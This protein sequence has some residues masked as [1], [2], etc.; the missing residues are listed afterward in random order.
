VRSVSADA[1]PIP[2]GDPVDEEVL[3][4]SVMSMGSRARGSR[5]RWLW[6]SLLPFGLGSWVPIVAGARCEVRRWTML[7]VLWSILAAVGWIAGLGE[8]TEGAYEP[9]SLLL[10]IV[11]WVGGFGTT[12]T[13][14]SSYTRQMA[15]RS[16]EAPARSDGSRAR[17]PWLSLLPLGVGV[18]APAVAGVRCGVR[19]WT[20]LGVVWS[21][22]ALVGWVIAGGS[23]PG[24][25]TEGLGVGLI[26][27][28]WIAGIV[29]S[30]VIRPRYERRAERYAPVRA[31]CPQ[32]TARSRQWTLRYALIAYVVT[33][34]VVVTSAAVLYYGAS[35]QLHVGVGVLIVDAILLG[36]LVPLR[37]RRGLTRQDLGLRATPAAR[38]I[39]L[40]ILAFV[41]YA[42]VAGVWV[43]VVHPRGGANTLAD[44]R[45][46]STINV[47]LAVF[48]VAVS[49]P[50]VEEIF[51]RG[52]L[53]RS[54]RNRLALLPAAL[55]A[56]TMFGLVHIT[57]YPLDTLPVKA[58]FGVIT[59]LLYERTGSLLP[60]I[61]LHSF[62]DATSIDVSLT[63]NDLIVLASFLSLAVVLLVWSSGPSATGRGRPVRVAGASGPPQ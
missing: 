45:D 26:F 13:I 30:F 18:W 17:W 58:A 46:Q 15:A 38:S 40:V 39:G 28:A 49:A 44:V 37:R 22:L 2:F 33:F 52:L 20:V 10:V 36:S 14:R 61:G 34:L 6:L 16:T 31:P 29:S 9:A 62:V 57:S 11:A 19:R 24:A 4:S 21:A 23:S 56:G 47:V 41:A 1:T 50:V 43:A 5:T 60:G 63:G 3:Q 53:Y 42:L 25:Q 59:C 55:I 27:L 32:P 51:F 8:P 7:G 48:A 54:L 12:L 35:V